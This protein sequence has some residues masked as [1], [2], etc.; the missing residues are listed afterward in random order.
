M[1]A[2][3]DIT[4]APEHKNGDI[5]VSTSLLQQRKDTATYT[6]QLSHLFC[7]L[8]IL[9]LIALHSFLRFWSKWNIQCHI[10]MVSTPLYTWM[11]Q[12]SAHLL[13][14]TSGFLCRCGRTG[15]RIEVI[16]ARIS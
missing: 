16:V 2:K 6:K 9:P 12:C 13:A 7:S 1:S 15:A 11:I 4:N 10:P 5:L 8:I 3:M 14:D